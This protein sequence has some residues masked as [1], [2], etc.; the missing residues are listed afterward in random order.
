VKHACVLA[1]ILIA[2][3]PSAPRASTTPMRPYYVSM[4]APACDVGDDV[5]AASLAAMRFDDAGSVRQVLPSVIVRASYDCVATTTARRLRLT[6]NEGFAEACTPANEPHGCPFV[7]ACWARGMEEGACDASD[8][9]HVDELFSLM[10]ANAPGTFEREVPA[11]PDAPTLYV[12]T[13]TALFG[14]GHL[15]QQIDG[16]W[17]V[18]L[19]TTVW[20]R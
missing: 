9:A 5:V 13:G 20:Q 18:V 16:A 1:A 6:T 4:A 3:G 7:R 14:A 19:T 15:V 11:Q 12:E 17:R 10:E 2:C 8:R